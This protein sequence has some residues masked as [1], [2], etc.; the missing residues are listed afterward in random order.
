MIELNILTRKPGAVYVYV[1]VF[2]CV[3]VYACVRVCVLV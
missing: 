3:C 1:C 2:E